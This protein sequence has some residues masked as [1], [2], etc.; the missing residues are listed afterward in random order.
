MVTAFGTFMDNKLSTHTNQ[1]HMPFATANQLL[2]PS[3]RHGHSWGMA[4]EG[5][6]SPIICQQ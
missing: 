5:C 6:S 2:G 1:T 4:M 3:R